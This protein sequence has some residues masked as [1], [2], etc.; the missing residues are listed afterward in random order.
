MEPADDD[1]LAPAAELVG[2][3]VGPRRLVRHAGQTDEVAR[4]VEV[5]RLVQVVPDR[6]VDALRH[7]SGQ[8]GERHPQQPSRLVLVDRAVGLEAG[9]L[10]E[11]NL[12]AKT[13]FRVAIAEAQS[14]RRRRE[15]LPRPHRAPQAAAVVVAPP[16]FLQGA[17]EDPTWLANSQ[18]RLQ[19]YRKLE[20]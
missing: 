12:H 20:K 11:Q 16:I 9:R 7:K 5:D 4:L 17:K 19:A 8:V 1:L 2:D 13:P 6:H 18:T 3:L 14:T 15:S 10:D